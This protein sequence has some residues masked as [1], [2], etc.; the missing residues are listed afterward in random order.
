MFFLLD[1]CAHG[2]GWRGVFLLLWY[3]L[4]YALAH[5]PSVIISDISFMTSR[6]A[7]FWKRLFYTF[8]TIKKCE[9]MKKTM[10]K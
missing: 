8:T 1:G 10:N 6:K 9:N 4:L 7:L 2:A 5:L 3:I